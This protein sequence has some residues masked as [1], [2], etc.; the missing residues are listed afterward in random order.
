MKANAI[1][2]AEQCGILSIPAIDEP[3]HL[4]DVLARW[5]A[6]ESTRRLIFCDEGEEDAD[7]LA[8]L[9]ALPPSRWRSSSAPK[10]ASPRTRR[11]MLRAA[12]FVTAIS[13]GAPYPARGHGRRG[14]AGGG[15]GGAR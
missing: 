12:P 14:R 6:E 13:L 3:A 11:A 4:A 9:K 5:P 8:T 1:E 10:A 15:A 2:A 7:P